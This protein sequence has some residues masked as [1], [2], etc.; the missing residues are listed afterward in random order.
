[1]CEGPIESWLGQYMSCVK[2]ALQQQ[3]ATAMGAE[4]PPIK[5]R[6]VRE[7]HSA[8]ARRVQLPE[9]KS[10]AGGRSSSKG[11]HQ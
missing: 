11:E 9:K 6:P 2:A 5:P 3:L 4:K 10:S 7:I 8:G 1:M